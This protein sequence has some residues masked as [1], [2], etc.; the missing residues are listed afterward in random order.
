MEKKIENYLEQKVKE[1]INSPGYSSLSDEKKNSLEK[2]ITVHLNRMVI[3]TFVNH[4]SEENAQKL[5]NLTKN[6]PSEAIKK[7]NELAFSTPDLAE[8][9]EKRI[10]KEVEKFKSLNS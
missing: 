5:S 10:N 8:S 2:K 1:V 4:L 6:D 7:I 9:L 3:E